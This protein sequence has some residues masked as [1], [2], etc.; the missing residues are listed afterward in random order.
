MKKEVKNMVKVMGKRLLTLGLALVM[1][2][3][4]I[5]VF[6]QETE[7]ATVKKKSYDMAIAET[8]KLN[9]QISGK[10][11]SAA[12]TYKSSKTSV[13][14]VSKK[15]VVTAKKAGKTQIT[16]TEVKG[17][18]KKTV[19]TMKVTVHKAERNQYEWYFSAAEGRYEKYPYQLEVRDFLNFVNPKAT[20]TWSSKKPKVITITK[21]GK[22]THIDASFLSTKGTTVTDTE[23][24][25]ET[26]DDYEANF[27]WGWIDLVIKETYKG[28]SRNIICTVRVAEQGLD[29][30]KPGSA[31]ELKQGEVFNMVDQWNVVASGTGDDPYH[32][33]ISEEL[34]KTEQ[35]VRAA[36]Q[37]IDDDSDDDSD[38]IYERIYNKDGY[39]TG[40]IKAK[41]TGKLYAYYFS[42]NYTKDSYDKY[43]G[44]YG[45]NITN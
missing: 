22:I 45:I 25:I 11:K 32:I 5:V 34:Y 23:A 28:K 20:Y 10:S 21:K 39:W 16:I 9:S 4:S 8:L 41:K 26:G 36:L 37:S 2:L 12:Y 18:K 42:H 15:G 3:S 1:L 24:E 17:G 27:K 14:S 6:S 38:D 43:L 30:I 33:L 40:E 29:G 7:A 31:I 19:G 35:E 44:Y 13:A